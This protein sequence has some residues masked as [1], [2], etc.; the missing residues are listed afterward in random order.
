MNKYLVYFYVVLFFFD[1]LNM[2]KIV[3]FEE[4]IMWIRVIIFY[5]ISKIFCI[6]KLFNLGMGLYYVYDMYVCF[7]KYFIMELYF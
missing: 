6:E 3:I 2:C 4:E 7:F 5:I 1:L